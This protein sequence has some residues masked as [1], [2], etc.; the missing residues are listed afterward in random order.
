MREELSQPKPPLFPS[1]AEIQDPRT[2]ASASATVPPLFVAGAHYPAPSSSSER[3]HPALSTAN[4]TQS[5]HQSDQQV[6][7]QPCSDHPLIA[8]LA[9]GTAS[10]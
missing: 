5:Q 3:P 7:H 8:S 9:T 10:R 6:L 1:A 2:K 4:P